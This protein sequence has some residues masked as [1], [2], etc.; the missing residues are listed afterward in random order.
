MVI[1]I[2]KESLDISKPGHLYLLEQ[3][4]DLWLATV[5]NSNGVSI[6]LV[7]LLPAAI[8]LL[9]LGTENLKKVLHILECNILL[10]PS[11]ILN[12]FADPLL[13]QIC[14]LL[15]TLTANASNSLLRLI[16]ITVQACYDANCFPALIQLMYSK[17]LFT[18]LLTTILSGTE[19]G[20]IVVGFLMIMSRMAIYDANSVMQIMHTGGGNDAIER[21]LDVFLEKYDSLGQA[22]QRKLCALA[23]TSLIGTGNTMVIQRFPAICT[24]LTS[25]YASNLDQN[26]M[27]LFTFEVRDG[28][29]DECSLDFTRRSI[30]KSK[31]LLFK[32]NSL[33]TFLKQKIGE[34]ESK[35]NQ[36]GLINS[37]EDAEIR[38]QMQRMIL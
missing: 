21:F 17:G 27:V 24:I 28:D 31:D 5:Q 4:L 22:K 1:P 14:G 9:E 32:E 7:N 25:V 20:V 36:T 33:G 30:L 15:G 35:L 3:G 37:I 6:D 19:L 29:D 10:A 11:E 34:C 26:D 8:Q 12:L 38:T 13:T 2:L 16:D 23:F 18:K